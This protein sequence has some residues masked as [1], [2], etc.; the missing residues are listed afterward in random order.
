M[1]LILA[2]AGAIGGT[3]ADQWK[4]VFVCDALK[5]DVIA[6]RGQKRVDPRRGSN[7]KGSDYVIS[8]GSVIIVNPGQ[9]AITLENGQIIDV[10]MQPGAYTFS[11]KAEP[12]IFA[13][14]TEHK[15][16]STF[17]TIGNRFGFGGISS[18]DHRVIYIK[19]SEVRGSKFGTPSPV[20]FRIVDARIGLDYE[21]SVRCNG[22]YTFKIADPIT[23]YNCVCNEIDINYEPLRTSTFDSFLRASFADAIQPAFADIASR[24]I[25]YS[26]LPAKENRQ[27]IRDAFAEELSEQWLDERG[28]QIGTIAI[29]SATISP[30]DEEYLKQA[31][32][33][34]MYSNP[35]M[36]AGYSVESQG[37]A[38]V[39]AANNPNGAMGGFIGMGMA[40]GVNRSDQY[41]SQA[42]A[43]GY[44][45]PAPVQG[46]RAGA[47]MQPNAQ[48][49][50]GGWQCPKCGNTCS[51]DSAF[52]NKCGTPKPQ[53]QAGGF[54][55]K[56]GNPVGGNDMFCPKCGNKLK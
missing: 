43:G 30:E 38:M 9:C 47:A 27:I 4:E 12:S 44:S 34:A 19:T 52:C 29:N 32:R 56:C 2:A 11:T 49:Q 14:S 21:A 46:G 40:Q 25:R 8:D 33:A 50:N 13:D 20:P 23:F 24:G 36:A 7:K 51:D 10:A 1:G 45:I 16:K 6:C 48:A 35:A 17:A 31:Q 28:I 5:G 37:R 15:V 55:G 42:Q 22:E 3:L 54:C 18:T 39:D 53:Q 26:E 41:F